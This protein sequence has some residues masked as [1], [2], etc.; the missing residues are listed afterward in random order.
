M[1]IAESTDDRSLP[2]QT[3][4]DRLPELS[5]DEFYRLYDCDRFTATVLTNRFRYVVSAVCTKVRRLSF[6]HIV[7]DAADLC[8]M[9]SGPPDLGYPMVAVSETLPLFYG[10]IPDAVRI[11]IDEYGPDRLRPGDLLICNDY[12]RVGTHMNDICAIRPVFHRGELVAAVTVRAHQIDVGGTVLQGAVPEKESVFQDGLRLPPMLLY[13]EGRPVTA[14]FKLLYD[15]TRKPNI[16]VPDLKTTHHTLE[17]AEEQLAETVARYG[18]DPFRGAM[19]YA[20]DA[21]AFAMAEAI[22][23]IPDGVYTGEEWL[24][25]DGSGGSAPLPVRVKI[26]KVGSEAE[27]DF[28]GSAPASKTAV[29]CSWLDVK[30]GVAMALKFLL[31]PRYPT[32]SGTLRNVEIVLDPNTI[33][34]PQPPHACSLYNYVV[35]SIVHA[36]YNA[37]NPV[38]G[39]DAVTASWTLSNDLA[40]GYPPGRGERLMFPGIVT[41]CGPWGA[42]RHCDGDSA[43]QPIFMNL[44]TIGGIETYEWQEPAI[45]LRSEYMPDTAGAGFNRGGASNCHDVMYLVPAKHGYQH[46]HSRR[47]LAGGGAYGGRSGALTAQWVWDGGY[48]DGGRNPRLLPLH[49]HDAVYRDS[50]PRGGVI[51]PLTNEADPEGGEYIGNYS[52]ISEQNRTSPGAIVRLVTAAGSGWGDP[53]QREPERVLAD[54]RDDYVSIDEAAQDYGV[55]I[56][57]QVDD[58]ERLRVDAPATAKLRGRVV[59]G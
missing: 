3:R 6:S 1:T 21:S 49:M 47:P 50:S 29:N 20:C 24:D 38:L 39:P 14:T 53:F 43:Q 44:S 57:G 59:G 45:V 54:V 7:R 23:R 48:T 16:I 5:A 13:S 8:G 31:D 10:S 19:N 30:T 22:A 42:T 51:N 27:F 4:P 56:I 11:V 37:L 33:M 55:V 26:S 36:I 18:L 2:D 17:W 9:L 46:L 12:Y 15:N 40:L 35:I 25:G 41:C 58:P 32:T 34:N 28:R 52:F